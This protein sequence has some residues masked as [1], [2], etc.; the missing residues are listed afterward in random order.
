MGM[1]AILFNGVKL[2]EK[3]IQYPFDRRPHVKS[4]SKWSSSF[5][6][7]GVLRLHNF[8]HVYSQGARADN[9]QVTKF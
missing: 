6:G 4:D 3:K 1:A 5:R 9:P 2:Y 8:I 7:E